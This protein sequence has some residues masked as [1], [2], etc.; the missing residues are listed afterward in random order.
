M[1][2]FQCFGILYM[3]SGMNCVVCECV[4]HMWRCLWEQ[5]YCPQYSRSPSVWNCTYR[6]LAGASCG[7]AQIELHVHMV[8]SPPSPAVCWRI[9]LLNAWLAECLLLWGFKA[10]QGLISLIFLF[11]FFGKLNVTNKNKCVLCFSG[12]KVQSWLK[13]N[14]YIYCNY[15]RWGK[16]YALGL[17]QNG[18]PTLDIHIFLANVYGGCNLKRASLKR[19]F[20]QKW[21]SVWTMITFQHKTIVQLRTWNCIWT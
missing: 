21:A 9:K 11:F 15:C 8:P 13:K 3:S 5:H 12:W 18:Q 6:V 16:K 17:G 1:C 4:W 20:T 7:W 10:S 14:I 2:N 19:Q